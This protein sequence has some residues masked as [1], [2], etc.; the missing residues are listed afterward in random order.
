MQNLR[1]TLLTAA[2]VTTTAAVFAQSQTIDWESKRTKF[3]PKADAA[4]DIAAAV[5][6]ATK[7]KKRILLDIGGEWCSW[8]HKLD[9]L[10][11]KDKDLAKF[12]HKNFILVKVNF[13]QENKNEAVLSNYPKITG[14]PHI[15][16]L[17]SDG[18]LLHSQDTGLLETG[19]HHDPAKVMD[20]FKKW[21]KK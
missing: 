20:F 21:A 18:T 1:A 2:L 16:V 3:N 13:S 6:K 4:A 12:E 15:F 5:K 9:I 14:Y 11:L 19:D 7:E 17:E 8:C 10:L